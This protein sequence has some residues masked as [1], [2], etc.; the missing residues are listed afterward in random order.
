MIT[1]ITPTCD[2]PTGI[3]LCERYMARQTVQPDQWIVADGGQAPAQLTMGQEHIRNPAPSG[4]GNLAG[5]ILAG[6]EAAR[7]NVIIII[8]DD[9]WYAPDHIERCLDGLAEASIYG[10]PWL[11]YYHVGV[12]RW[13]KLRN[14]GAAL[15]QTAFRASEAPRLASAATAAMHAGD[16][17]IDGRFWDGRQNA[18]TGAQTV[19]GIKGLPGQSGLGVGHRPFA[20][21]R[22]WAD[23]ADGVILRQW[24][25]ADA[26]PYLR[27][28][29][30]AVH[31]DGVAGRDRS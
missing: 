20:A 25:G 21:G 29:D 3:A 26:D 8:E 22:P 23:D 2:R 30:G 5:N 31:D 28:A 7:G 17:R 12:R 16:Y 6:L 11:H 1:L 15:C 9:D 18:A 27:L 14:S 10:C 24:L 13:I 19:V 4:A